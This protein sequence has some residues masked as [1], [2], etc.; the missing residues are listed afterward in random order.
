[1][2]IENRHVGAGVV[3]RGDHPL[4]DM[5]LWSIRSVLAVEPYIK[6]EIEPG[7]EFDWNVRYDYYT[8]APNA[9]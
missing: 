1:M 5:F 7:S 3:I 8:L 4:T 6:M 2:R 9:K